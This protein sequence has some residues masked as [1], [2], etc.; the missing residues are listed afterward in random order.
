MQELARRLRRETAA[1]PVSD[2]AAVCR[3]PL[4]SRAQ[5]LPDIEQRGYRDVRLT[6]ESAMNE[7]D[8]QLWTDGIKVDGERPAA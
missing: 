1:V 5:Y 7:E 4:L 8:I 3:G 2:G 6:H